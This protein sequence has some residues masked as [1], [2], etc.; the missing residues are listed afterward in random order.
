MQRVLPD[1]ADRAAAETEG[2]LSSARGRVH[3]AGELGAGG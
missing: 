3:H 2:T 1:E